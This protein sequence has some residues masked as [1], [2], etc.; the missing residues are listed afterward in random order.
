MSVSSIE[1]SDFCV[2][3]T[4]IDSYANMVVVG[5]QVFLFSHSCQYA[6]VRSFTEEVQALPKIS[7]EYSVISYDF[8]Y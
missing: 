7:I 1:K 6:N 8:P 2:S 5:Y 4:E 3:N